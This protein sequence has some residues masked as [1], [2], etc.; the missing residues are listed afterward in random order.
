MRDQGIRDLGRTVYDIIPAPQAF[1]GVLYVQGQWEIL[2]M[3]IAGR[4][5]RE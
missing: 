3:R 2:T 1:T 5:I 4:M